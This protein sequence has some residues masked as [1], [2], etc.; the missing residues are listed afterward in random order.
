MPAALP[1]LTLHLRIKPNKR[2]PGPPLYCNG[3]LELGISAP[4]VEGKAN[5]AVIATLAELLELPKSAFTL[6]HGLQSRQKQV[7]LRADA[8]TLARVEAWL[9]SL[10]G[11]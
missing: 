2:K 8:P 10:P 6:T 11:E 4:P 1:E 5:M 9:H 7:E 3:V